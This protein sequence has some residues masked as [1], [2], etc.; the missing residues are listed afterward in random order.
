[1]SSKPFSVRRALDNDFN[2]T[3]SFVVPLV[4]WA[5]YLLSL[6]IAG[7][8]P[9]LLVLAIVV[10]LLSPLALVLR[11]RQMRALFEQGEEVPG[12]LVKVFFFQDR[13]RIDYLYTV[14]EKKYNGS[15]AIH[16]NILTQ[17]FEVGQKVVI[18]VDKEN[19]ER[20]LLFDLYT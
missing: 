5:V 14:A 7:G 3:V 1:M 20:A 17:A 11:L 18:V 2:L 15:I 4:L 6:M 16:K 9:F 19:P 8:S 10:T 13:G 12:E